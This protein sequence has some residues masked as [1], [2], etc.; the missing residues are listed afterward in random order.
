M[1]TLLSA[2]ISTLVGSSGPPREVAF[3]SSSEE[4]SMW[5]QG[6]HHRQQVLLSILCCIAHVGDVLVWLYPSCCDFKTLYISLSKSLYRRIALELGKIC[7]ASVQYSRYSAL[8][9]AGKHSML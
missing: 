7:A 9:P 3:T 6:Q 8:L 4:V 1:Q 5:A 2:A